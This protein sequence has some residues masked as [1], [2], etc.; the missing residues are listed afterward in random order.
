MEGL[1]FFFFYNIGLLLVLSVVGSFLGQ[2][3]EFFFVGVLYM[4]FY[5]IL[6]KNLEIIWS[7]LYFVMRMIEMRIGQ[8][9]LL[10]VCVF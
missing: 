4:Y 6:G 2:M 3:L 10:Q 5:L 8:E 7:K 1:G 9:L